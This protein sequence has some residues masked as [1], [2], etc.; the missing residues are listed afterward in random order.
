[1]LGDKKHNSKVL[2]LDRA[3]RGIWRVPL[4]CT[5]PSSPWLA[6]VIHEH[7]QNGYFIVIQNLLKLSIYCPQLA[8]LVRDIGMWEWIQVP[9]EFKSPM[10]QQKKKKKNPFTKLYNG[11]MWLIEESAWRPWGVFV[12][13]ILAHQSWVSLQV[14]RPLHHNMDLKVTQ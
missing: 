8:Q 3:D 12:S 14:W 5:C 4:I 2:K 7:Q 9:N 6:R 11:L 13:N 10:W 1:M